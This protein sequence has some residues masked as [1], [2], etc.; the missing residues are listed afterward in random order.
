MLNTE[1]IFSSYLFTT[2]YISKLEKLIKTIEFQVCMY[3]FNC[4]IT[5]I[6]FDLCNMCCTTVSLFPML[7]C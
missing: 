1:G 5:S 4:F 2:V 6:C 7:L 3:S